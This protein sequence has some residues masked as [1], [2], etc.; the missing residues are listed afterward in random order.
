METKPKKRK[1]PKF[2]RSNFGRKERKRVKDNWRK[3]RGIDN[4][5]RLKI[6]WMGAEPN[7]GW[8]NPER[9][10]G[11]HPSGA[12]EVLVHNVYELENIEQ[13][14]AVR[15][16]RGVGRRKRAMITDEAAN[17]GLRVLNA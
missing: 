12:R 9:I 16:A 2:F 6:K 17:M 14:C 4:K 5:K 7:I 10:R 11:L 1:H 13:G 8:K 15:I 3:P